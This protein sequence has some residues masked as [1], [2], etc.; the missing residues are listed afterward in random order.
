MNQGLSEKQ[1]GKKIKPEL[2]ISIIA[3]VVAIVST[4][5]SVYFS[6]L[7]I[8]T[9]IFPVLVLAYDP[10]NGWEIRNIGNGPAINIMV[11]HQEH[12][13]TKWIKPTRIYPISKDGKVHLKWV[14]YNPNKIA[15]TYSDIHKNN[16][17]SI[18]NDDLTEIKNG[19]KLPSWQEDEII[20]IWE[21]IK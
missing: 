6:K 15:V 16:Y 1:N 4:I 13:E 18:T 10:K 17:T 3:L 20:R 8:R 12:G 14:G 19:N 11:S 7:N 21:H 2:L 9:D 5:I